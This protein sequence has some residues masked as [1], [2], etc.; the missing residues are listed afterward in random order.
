M[1]LVCDRVVVGGMVFKQ[2]LQVT[3]Y[4]LHLEV[5]QVL[6]AGLRG[7]TIIGQLTR[8]TS[9]KDNPNASED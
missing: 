3:S 1:G 8:N 5:D 9:I 6:Q 7:R 4:R 2:V